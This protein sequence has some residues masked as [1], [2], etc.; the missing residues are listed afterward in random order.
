MTTK[1][2]NEAW[3]AELDDIVGNQHLLICTGKRCIC[4][5]EM[6]SFIS[7]LLANAR[8][9]ER[10]AFRAKV[11]KEIDGKIGICGLHD[12]KEPWNYSK[13][14]AICKQANYRNQ[15][16]DELKAHIKALK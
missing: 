4:Q 9:D 10:E 8:K 3:E 5:T 13:K 12:D 6:K 14:C 7:Q 2:N 1:P 15:A 16:L 11:L